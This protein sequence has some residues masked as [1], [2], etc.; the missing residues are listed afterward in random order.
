MIL[1]V[2][3]ER[4]IP[5]LF[6]EVT[7]YADVTPQT[8]EVTFSFTVPED[9]NILLGMSATIWFKDPE[10][11]ASKIPKIGIP[12][13]AIAI[14]GEQKYVWVVDKKTMLVSR[15]N[16]TIEDDVGVVLS[17]SSGLQL[18]EVIVAVG[19]S[20]FSEGMKVCPLSK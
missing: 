2:S 16:I 1:S 6:K 12:L 11:I 7:L 5:V 9:L 19:V 3:P 15:R 18:G 10:E 8:Y 4:R 20:F 13:T 17:V 14:D